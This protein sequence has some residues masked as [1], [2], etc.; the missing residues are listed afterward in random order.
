LT[1]GLTDEK[2]YKL[3]STC[4]LG[5]LL[6]ERW[7]AWSMS[8]L[9]LMAASVPIVAVNDR[10]FPEILGDNYPYFATRKNFLETVERAMNDG[11]TN[12]LYQVGELLN[13][14]CER[15]FSWDTLSHYWFQDIVNLTFKEVAGQKKEEVFDLIKQ[16]KVRTK[17]DIS[18]YYSVRRGYTNIRNFLLDNGVLDNASSPVVS[19]SWGR[20]SASIDDF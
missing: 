18:K 4:D 15:L 3:L 6:H 7:G 1:T 13:A 8:A 2:Y 17:S 5:F 14:R 16:G 10:S 11:K 19:Y 20:Q 9:D 12:A